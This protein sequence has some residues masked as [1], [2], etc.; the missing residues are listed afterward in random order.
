M[1][2]QPGR[3]NTLLGE[4]K[5]RHVIRV[6]AVYAIVGWIVI[7]VAETVLPALALPPWTV[8]FV[9]VLVL[10]GAP[11]AIG[12]AWAYDITP[13]GVTRA[14][15]RSGA[16]RNPPAPEQPAE[17]NERKR[18]IVLPFRMLRPDAEA[19]FLAFG[20]PDAITSSLSTLHSLVVR[21]QLAALRFARETPDLGEIAER[22]AVDVIVTGTIV[23]VGSR[24]RV[25]AELTDAR[26]GT[27]LWSDE[28]DSD[29]DD[30][31]RLQDELT[32]SIV[33]SLRVRLSEREDHELET[34]APATARAYETYLRANR[35]AYELGQWQAARDLYLRS[36]EEDPAFAPAWARLGRC[37]R[38]IAKYGIKPEE[39]EQNL[40]RARNAF[41]RAL[42]L[43][44][45]LSLAHN[46]YAQLEVDL[47][48]AEPALRRLLALLDGTRSDPEPYAGLVH[49]CR[50]AGL[51]EESLAAHDAAQ[52]IDPTVITSVNHTYWM[53]G[54]YQR[55]FESTLSGGIG[56]LPGLALASLGR[57]GEA[58][59][60]LR[61][62]EAEQKDERPQAYLRSLRALLEGNEAAA[63]AA[64]DIAARG[65]L[66]GEAVYYL[67]RTYAR[68]GATEQALSELERAVDAG[69]NCERPFATDSWL[70]D[71]RDAPRFRELLARVA[72][73]HQRARTAFVEAGGEALL[74]TPPGLPAEALR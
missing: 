66:D 2:T 25:T 60:I 11:M 59:E 68:L 72:D 46:L 70:D 28:R 4:L 15:P 30:L 65:L 63:L 26:E 35:V 7:Q 62:H 48:R 23:C 6:T 74:A 73:R 8:T 55:A 36:L 57:T 29:M 37:Y 50:F 17:H 1:P 39:D 5:R 42:S 58:S 13:S 54:A 32:R 3:L 44:P 38:L 12:L 27:L 64:L 56:Y 45:Q 20:L 52:R 16:G 9:V 19:E 22:A 71:L 33:S 53:L 34:A 43:N 31:F 69:F 61:R 18:L 24:V 49:A 41:E 10:L 51:L 14:P 47:G 40:A 67:A 21:S